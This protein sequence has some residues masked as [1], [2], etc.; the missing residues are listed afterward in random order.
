MRTFTTTKTEKLTKGDF[1]HRLQS[2]DKML[3]VH[4][5]LKDGQGMDQVRENIGNVLLSLQQ[6]NQTR[7]VVALKSYGADML[8]EKGGISTLRHGAGAEYY[9]VENILIMYAEDMAGICCYL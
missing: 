5:D 4:I 8:T 2:R 9:E 1:F 6:N 3:F 7:K